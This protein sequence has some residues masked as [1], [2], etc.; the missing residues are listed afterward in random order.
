MNVL[1]LDDDMGSLLGMRMTLQLLGHCC[2]AYNSP[3]DALRCYDNTRFDVIITDL[4]MPGM[5]GVQFMATAQSGNPSVPVIII[6]GYLDQRW[7]AECLKR[8]AVAVLRK[9]LDA[10]ELTRILNTISARE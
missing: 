5:N 9:P 8:G 2:E 6:S 4:R 1:L 10:G 7:E 3:T